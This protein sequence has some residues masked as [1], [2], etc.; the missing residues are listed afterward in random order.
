MP[1]TK[2]PDPKT[3]ALRHHGTLNPHPDKV[4]D[5]LFAA[6]DFFDARDLVQVKYEMVR[7]VH[8]DG[9]A[10]SHSAAAFGFSRPCFYQAQAALESGGL[11]ALVPRKPGP[12]RSHKLD[13]EV[14][15]FVQQL[16]DDD[17]S[18]RPAELA[19]RVRERFGRTVHPRSVERALARR[20][21]KRR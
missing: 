4:L 3:A 5:P 6:V 10:V 1:K 11:V 2:P 17:A 18:L 15:D 21:K 9:Q 8:V 19:D 7:R 14:M 12:R 16:R 13:T 20:G